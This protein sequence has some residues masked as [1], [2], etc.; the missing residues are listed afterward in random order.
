MTDYVYSPGV[1][2]YLAGAFYI[3]GLVIIHQVVLRLLILSGTGVYLIYYFTVGESPLWE[4][5]YVSLL[6]GAANLIGLTSLLARKSRLAIPRA[7]ADI[8]YDFPPL[9]PGDFRALMK[10]ARRYTV[11]KDKQV[12]AE[13]EAGDKLYFI[14]SGSTLVRKGDQAFVLKPKLFLGEIAF[15]IGAPSSASAWLEEGAEVLE[16]RFDTLRRKCLRSAR[17]KLA[18]EAA[19]SAD[20]AHKVAHSMGKDS[21]RLDNI[22]K[23]MVDALASVGQG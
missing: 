12:T 14:I 8:Y 19:I 4:A 2:V 18:L 11:D 10:L 21:V 5:I 9:P 6:I 13:G 20:L 17:F 23:P 1:L 16:W 15:L 22:P 7:H 3:L